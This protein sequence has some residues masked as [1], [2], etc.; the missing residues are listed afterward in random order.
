MNVSK[1]QFK[2]NVRVFRI[3]LYFINLI[4]FIY[5][6]SYIF[7]YVIEERDAR[8]YIHVWAMPHFDCA[9]NKSKSNTT[10]TAIYVGLLLALHHSLFRR[11]AHAAGLRRALATVAHLATMYGWRIIFAMCLMIISVLLSH[12]KIVSSLCWQCWK[13]MLQFALIFSLRTLFFPSLGVSDKWHG[14]I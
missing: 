2:P 1:L 13:Q 7:I 8:L 4:I 5:R 3:A 10:F 11:T 6:H 12:Q 9:K 14:L